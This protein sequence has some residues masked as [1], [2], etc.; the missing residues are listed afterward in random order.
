M[1][2]RLQKY[3]ASCGVAS[4]RKCEEII[5][6]GRVKVDGA[7]VRELGTKIDID[8]SVV[9]IDGKIIRPEEEKV[10]ILL[11]KP[12]GYISAV[13]DDR[14][15]KTIVDL[16]GAKERI[17]PIGRLDYD[18]S[19]LIL[20][21][22]DGDVYNKVIHPR[23][24]INKVYVAEVRGI[25][26]DGVKKKFEEGIDIGDYM[27]APGK[28]KV[29][30]KFKN[31]ALVEITIHEGRNRQVRR[32]CDAV[33]FPVLTL[34]RISVGAIELKGDL[35]EG[36]WRNLTEREVDYLKRGCTGNV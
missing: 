26:N 18:T 14:G 12:V 33:G 13:S 6:A 17:F 36:Q 7:I 31:S 34:R 24:E 16:I 23:G 25:P 32:M 4:R 2:E 19:G 21:T 11:N 5:L 35:N 27:T 10:Y 3:M 20:L 29:L 28:F 30:K 9:E 8:R 1:Q 15:R 22:N